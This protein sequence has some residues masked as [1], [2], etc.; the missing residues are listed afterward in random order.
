MSEDAKARPFTLTIHRCTELDYK[1]F[2]MSSKPCKL[3]YTPQQRL[4]HLKKYQ[5]TAEYMV[6][7]QKLIVQKIIKGKFQYGTP[8]QQD[9]ILALARHELKLLI[10]TD[11]EFKEEIRLLR[12]QSH[13]RALSGSRVTTDQDD[14]TE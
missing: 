8:S 4:D 2:E 7:K 6:K 12:R 1:Q 11:K 5:T 13:E 14:L 3:V 9:M 10:Q